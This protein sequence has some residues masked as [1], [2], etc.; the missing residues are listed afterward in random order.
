MQIE[1]YRDNGGRFHWRSYSVSS[2]TKQ[3][4]RTIAITVRAMPEGLLSSPRLDHRGGGKRRMQDLVPAHHAPAMPGQ[5]S[6][7]SAVP[8]PVAAQAT[9]G[10][11]GEEAEP[12]LEPVQE[13]RPADAAGEERDPH[14]CS[15]RPSAACVRGPALSARRSRSPSV[16]T[17]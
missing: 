10:P 9:P 16:S 3:R 11:A 13:P 1:I 7:R 15:A 14:P 8:T 5:V 17:S 4:G 6:S 12:V 2:P